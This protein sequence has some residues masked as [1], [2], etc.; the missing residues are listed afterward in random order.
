[1]ASSLGQGFYILP[2]LSIRPA[3]SNERDCF[4]R[5]T[6]ADLSEVSCLGSQISLSPFYS[7]GVEAVEVLI[8]QFAPNYIGAMVAFI[9]LCKIS[10]VGP[11]LN[12]FHY[13]FSQKV[14]PNLVWTYLLVRYKNKVILDLPTFNKGW[15]DSY[16]FV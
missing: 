1:M 12:L 4:P 5:Q 6:R 16:I 11:T 7:R 3:L 14:H 13:F 9:A 2:P 15:K 8:C 10:K